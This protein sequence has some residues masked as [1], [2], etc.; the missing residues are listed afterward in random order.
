MIANYPAFSDGQLLEQILKFEQLHIKYHQ[1]SG[2]EVS[3][4]LISAVLLRSLPDELCAH[5]TVSLPETCSYRDLRV[6]LLR[7]DR[8]SQK[9]SSQ[10]IN[11]PSA[12]SND[13]RPWKLIRFVRS[14]YGA[15]EARPKAKATMTL[16]RGSACSMLGQV[17]KEE[18]GTG[19]RQV[20]SAKTKVKVIKVARLAVKMGRLKAAKATAGCAAN[21]VI[22]R[23]SVG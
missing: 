16:A 15:K 11:A 18:A 20:V 17:G 9:W 12:S 3:D 21:Q 10:A 13:P 5:A 7:W 14:E 2:K 4:E 1:A 19:I 23:M 22:G 8:S 6:L